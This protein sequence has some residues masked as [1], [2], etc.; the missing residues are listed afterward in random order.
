MQGVGNDFVVIDGRSLS[1][2]WMTLAPSLCDRKFGIGADGLLVITHSVHADLR[3][4][5]F[6]PDGSPDI[7]GNGLRC[8]A[9]Y[10]VEHGI[11]S[12]NS[13][14]V[15]TLAGNRAVSVQ[16][17]SFGII[18]SVTVDMGKP[19]FEP[20]AIPLLAPFEQYLQLD[21]GKFGILPITP[22]STGSTHAITFVEELPK[23]DKFYAVSST[24][25]IHPLFPQRTSLMWCKV[26]GEN[27][28]QIR[29][30]ERGAGETMGCGTGACATVVAAVLHG[31]VDSSD[32]IEVVSAG[33]SLFIRWQLGSNILMRGPAETT[34]SGEISVPSF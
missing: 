32:E 15:E 20:S 27:R 19:L 21:L 31:L 30:W 14:C 9:R 22:L 24:V 17:D 13:F 1:H 10:V 8:I 3:M 34:F 18:Q 6:N 4:L 28:V 26:L 23:D 16:Q 11:L 25:E 7:C 29:I 2:D 5:M 12:Q 33:G